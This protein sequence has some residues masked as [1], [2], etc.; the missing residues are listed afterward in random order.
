MPRIDSDLLPQVRDHPLHF[1]I[2]VAEQRDVDR[3][4]PTHFHLDTGNRGQ[5]L[6]DRLLE[7]LL[8]AIA[9][10]A[11]H[12][13]QIEP[14]GVLRALG[15]DAGVD[16]I[17]F[18]ELAQRLL[19]ALDAL[20]GVFEAGADRHRQPHAGKAFVALRHHL[21]SD[22]A[23]NRDRNREAQRR[24]PQRDSTRV[25]VAKRGFRWL[26]SSVRSARQMP[27]AGR[28]IGTFSFGTVLPSVHW[29]GDRT[30]PSNLP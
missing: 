16:R 15:A 19:D 10:G 22:D 28:P 6:T 25:I 3:P 30:Q 20:V 9:L 14:P 26:A 13:F 2:V 8:R 23:G 5:P 21:G 11:R 27:I 7:L 4:A 1:G 18:L 17:D 12:E 24:D 29:R